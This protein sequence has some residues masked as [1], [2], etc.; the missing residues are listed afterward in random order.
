MVKEAFESPLVDA[1]LA[2]S[3]PTNAASRKVLEK[4]GFVVC[5]SGIDKDEG[6][7]EIWKKTKPPNHS[8]E[9]TPSSVTRPAEQAARQT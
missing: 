6:P 7:V 4:S 1:V 2:S 8:T 9:P 5:G 3:L